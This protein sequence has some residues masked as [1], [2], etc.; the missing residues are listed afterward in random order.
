MNESG[1]GEDTVY[2]CGKSRQ[3][4]ATCHVTFPVDVDKLTRKIMIFSYC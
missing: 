2:I 3:D 4:V 1:G